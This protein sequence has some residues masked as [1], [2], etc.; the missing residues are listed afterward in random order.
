[1]TGRRSV[2]RSRYRSNSARKSR[3]VRI[4]PGK[5][6]VW[7]FFAVL[8]TAFVVTASVAFLVGFRWL[9][10]SETLALKSIE[11]QGISHL[12][13]QEVARIAGVQLGD[14]VLNLK[15]ADMEERLSQNP[16]TDVV[17]VRRIPPGDL[18]I[19]IQE[20][21]PYYWILKKNELFYADVFGKT[22]DRVTAQRILSLPLLEYD[23]GGKDLVPELPEL[24]S[25]LWLGQTQLQPG[26]AAL[27]QVS[28][29]FIQLTFE[30]PALTFVLERRDWKQNM[31]KLRLVWADLVRRGE[32]TQVKGIRIVGG[33]VFVRA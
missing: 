22:I 31:H 6:L 1:M 2:R 8:G 20:R 7:L 10:T 4:R 13:S 32:S 28:R 3:S 16:W 25:Q 11:V 23:R 9:T 5:A 14:N 15:I 18:R 26:D 17:R 12:S 24:L 29:R 21:V 19:S 27:V 30:Q 33:K